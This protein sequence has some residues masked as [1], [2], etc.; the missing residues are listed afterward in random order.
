MGI[1]G[2]LVPKIVAQR[3]NAASRAIVGVST[4]T[5][6]LLG[7]FPQ[8]PLFTPKPIQSFHACDLV[9]GG[10]RKP[11][12]PSL[13]VSQFF[14]NGGKKLWIISTGT[15]LSR[16]AASFLKGL[17]VLSRI[18]S[19]NTILIPETSQLPEHE[20]TKV[21]SAAIPLAEK[22][23]ALY[24]LDPPQSIPLIHRGKG[25]TVW[26]RAQQDL[27]H[28]NVVVYVPRIRVRLTTTTSKLVAISASGT[29]A[30]VYARIDRTRG[31]WSTPAG[32]E[33]SLLGVEELERILTSKDISVLTRANMNAFKMLSSSAFAAWGARTLSS[34]S[35]W[36]YIAVRRTALFLEQ[37][38][39]KGLTWTTFEHNDVALWAAI[40]QV[41]NQFLQ[42]LFRR[43]A[44]QGTRAKDAYFVK[45]GRAT[46]TAAD[47]AAG[48]LNIILGF[49]PLKPAEFIV[50][51]IQLQA[52]TR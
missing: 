18:Q 19:V 17:S 13:V 40:R 3:T 14:K 43:G 29:M 2:S 46:T 32:A 27:H 5:A 31:V 37:S 28:P 24:L 12:L 34:R 36:K 33:A 7:S 49:A 30:G 35:E 47:Q 38:L 9:F 1:T 44:F 11:T 48:T 41:V 26:V 39:R 25:L 21:F 15:R 10:S 42:D 23:Q 16:N 52:R 22:R 50:L 20:A 51:N 8:G 45:C 4:S 6:V